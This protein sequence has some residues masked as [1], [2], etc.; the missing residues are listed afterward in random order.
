MPKYDK[1]KVKK[2]WRL[3]KPP[4]NHNETFF[5][6]DVFGSYKIGIIFTDDVRK[7]VDYLSDRDYFNTPSSQVSQDTT[8]CHIDVN[9]RGY[10]LFGDDAS[11]GTIA[12]E[13]WH[14]VYAAMKFF[15]AEVED[16]VVAYHLGYAVNKVVDFKSFLMEKERRK[17]DRR[18]KRQEASA[19]RNGR[20]DRDRPKPKK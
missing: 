10:L 20:P 2:G 1:V 17:N 12:H 16:E 7:S 9:G 14:A 18:R 15:G 19:G 13:C 3:R 6:F 5:T 11:V 8:A 4:E